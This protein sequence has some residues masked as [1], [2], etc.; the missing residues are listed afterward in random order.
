MAALTGNE[1][2]AFVETL[3]AGSLTARYKL[4]SGYQGPLPDNQWQLDVEHWHASTLAAIQGS[5]VD[6]ATGPAS[7]DMRQYWVP[8]ENEQQQYLCNNQVSCRG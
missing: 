4:V 3:G 8:P 1:L 7:P 2:D 5:A 6:A